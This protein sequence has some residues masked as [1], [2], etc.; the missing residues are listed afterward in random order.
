MTK[1]MLFRRTLALV[2]SL[3]LVVS[4]TA[5]GSE[6]EPA[7]PP[8]EA[9]TETT[10]PPTT[11][12][13]TEE[14]APA[15]IPEATILETEEEWDPIAIHRNSYNEEYTQPEVVGHALTAEEKAF[16]T[17]FWELE[18]NSMLDYVKENPDLIADGWD[19]IYVNEAGYDEDGIDVRTIFGE[20][21]LGID[22]ENQILVLRVTGD[23]YR[24]VLAIAKDPSRL[25]LC[26]SKDL[27][28]RGES[29]GDIALRYDGL[30]AITGS[31]FID[32]NGN[33]NGGQLAGA[34][35]CDGKSYG[36]HYGYNYERLELW[37]DDVMHIVNADSD[38]SSHTTDA[39]EFTPPLVIEG[40][41]VGADDPIFIENN[42]RACLGQSSTG[43]VMMLGIEGRQS[44][45]AG[46][47]AGECGRILLL[48]DGWTAMNMDGGSSASMWFDGKY[49][50]RCSNTSLKEGRYLPNVWVYGRETVE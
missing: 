34:C 23:S 48:H 42:P 19:H 35:M 6:P 47:D 43:E 40:R 22:A 18:I 32:P 9:P 44:H 5:C 39:S 13:P 46:T 25:H 50:I 2:L 49:V 29:A 37:D 33:G 16:F 14:T 15:T 11:A 4:M 10:V 36:Y 31:G 7:E 20:Q 8:T 45:S 26:P 41:N 27:G 3:L 12:A 17:M 1:K 28:S 30:L 38:F 21:V 24:G